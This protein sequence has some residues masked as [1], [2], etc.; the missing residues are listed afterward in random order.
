MY[1]SGLVPANGT[2]LFALSLKTM[3]NFGLALSY[4]V[5]AFV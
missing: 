2:L 5:Y 3:L 4:L 1:F